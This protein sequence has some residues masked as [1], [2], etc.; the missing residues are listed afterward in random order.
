[1][2][3]RQNN[4]FSKW[5]VVLLV[6]AQI[7]FAV[8]AAFLADVPTAPAVLLIMLVSQQLLAWLIPFVIARRIVLY[9]TRRMQ[10]IQGFPVRLTGEG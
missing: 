2:K 10:R 5:F 8:P 6:P 3:L 1:M 4:G 7:L 9:K